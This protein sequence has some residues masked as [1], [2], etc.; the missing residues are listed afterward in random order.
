VWYIR[1]VASRILMLEGLDSKQSDNIHKRNSIVV[2][3]KILLKKEGE[4][5]HFLH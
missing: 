2:V 1:R 3:K 5:K 4:Q